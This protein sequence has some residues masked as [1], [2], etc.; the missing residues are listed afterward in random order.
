M[1]RYDVATKHGSL[2][3]TVDIVS[4]GKTSDDRDFLD[5]ILVIHLPYGFEEDE[6]RITASRTKTRIEMNTSKER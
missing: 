6:T 1:I 2:G 5:F 3:I 4:I